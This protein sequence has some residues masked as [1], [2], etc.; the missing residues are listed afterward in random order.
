MHISMKHTLSGINL[1]LKRWAGSV[2]AP[3]RSV[4]VRCG[5]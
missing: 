3:F 1:E 2:A 5:N 4:V